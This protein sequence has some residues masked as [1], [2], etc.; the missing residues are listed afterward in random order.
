[1]MSPIASI[2]PIADSRAETLR[3]G[4]DVRGDDFLIPRSWSVPVRPC[5]HHFIEKSGARRDVAEVADG[6]EITFRRPAARI[7]GAPTTRRSAMNADTVSGRGTLEF[8]FRVRAASRATK[9]ASDSTS[10]SFT[11]GKRRVTWDERVRQQRRVGSRRKAL[12]P[13]SKR[14]ERINVIA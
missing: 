6:A 14:P 10:C 5:A 12:P 11:R 1:M 9:S 13:G 7:G 4:L 8:G 2:G 3:I